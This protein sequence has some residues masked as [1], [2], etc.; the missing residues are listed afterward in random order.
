MNST[1]NNPSA[2][3]FN[4]LQVKDS[5]L[6]VLGTAPDQLSLCGPLQERVNTSCWLSARISVDRVQISRACIA[7]SLA[8]LQRFAVD[9][10]GV[11]ER[12]R[13]MVLA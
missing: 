6:V 13:A 3:P 8:L 1:K 9:M 7:R 2:P 4:K 12:K 10:S 5:D 11:C